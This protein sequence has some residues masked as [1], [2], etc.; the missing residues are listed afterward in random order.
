MFYRHIA[1][2]LLGTAGALLLA[3]V[4]LRLFAARPSNPV[5]GWFF[6]V[7]T[8][9]SWLST[10]DAGQPRFGA[11]LEFS[12]LVLALGCLVLGFALGRGL[13]GYSRQR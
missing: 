3:R 8:L 13:R 9:P 12:T 10:L 7:T 4:V 6:A 11:T 1:A 2:M 5:F